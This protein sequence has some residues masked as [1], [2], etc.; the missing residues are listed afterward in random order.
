[1][2]I[3][4]GSIMYSSKKKSSKPIFPS[5]VAPSNKVTKFKETFSQSLMNYDVIRD[6]VQSDF[7]PKQPTPEPAQ[8]KKSKEQRKLINF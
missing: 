8:T 3:T 4:Y 2:S 6:K 7:K 5:D 1:M